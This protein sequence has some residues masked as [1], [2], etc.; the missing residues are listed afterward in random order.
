MVVS[1]TEVPVLGVKLWKSEPIQ[2]LR[3]VCFYLLLLA[4]KVPNQFTEIALRRLTE[5]IVAPRL[6][7]DD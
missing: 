2:I 6:L 3:G 5:L 1:V 4:N 7:A